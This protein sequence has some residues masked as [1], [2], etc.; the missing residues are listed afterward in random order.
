MK[1]ILL[2][3]VVINLL[4]VASL[5]PSREAS[6]ASCY[7]DYCSNSDPSKTG[8]SKSA[9]TQTAT[10]VYYAKLLPFR[11]N[12]YAGRL[13]LRASKTC[14]TQWARF[15][16]AADIVYSLIVVQPATRYT[17]RIENI[18]EGQDGWSMQ[19]Y[20]PRLCVYGK[21]ELYDADSSQFVGPTNAKTACI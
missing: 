19:I 15:T 4:L 16:A 5:V 1:R 7:G 13:E 9:W 18:G 8:C 10:D 11:K 3:G 21:I 2:C 12:Y 17:T 14:G 6:A 20:S